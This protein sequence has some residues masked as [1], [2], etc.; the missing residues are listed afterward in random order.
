MSDTKKNVLVILTSHDT[1]DKIGKPTGW[2][3]PELAH[4]YHILKDHVN[5]TIASPKGGEAPLDPGSKNTSDEHCLSF[6]KNDYH[7]VQNTIKLSDITDEQLKSHYDAVLIPGG[8]GPMY[9]LANDSTSHK[10]IATMYENNKYIAAV[11]HGPAAIAN[12]KLSDGTYMVAGKNVT[13]FT[14]HEEDIAKLT[15]AMPFSLETQLTTNGATFT[16]HAEPWGCYTV[17]DGYLIT[18][19]NPASSTEIGKQL[20]NALSS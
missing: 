14:N 19:Q 18:G 17:V 3:L 5:I 20:L 6:L 7:I 8:H 15:D 2:Y 4:P 1:I 11:C 10:I 16:K 9:D 13:S 12:V